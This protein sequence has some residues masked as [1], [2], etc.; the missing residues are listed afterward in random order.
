MSV[1]ARAQRCASAVSP[2]F[3]L[4]ESVEE[5]VDFGRSLHRNL[6]HVRTFQLVVLSL[7]DGFTGYRLLCRGAVDRWVVQARFLLQVCLSDWA[8]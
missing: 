5:Q 8:V 1:H 3:Q 4:A 2:T 7:V 6:V